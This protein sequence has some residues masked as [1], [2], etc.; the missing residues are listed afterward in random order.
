MDIAKAFEFFQ[1]YES[2]QKTEKEKLISEKIIKE[3]KERLKFL[4]DVGLD[5]LTLDRTAA[6]LSG[7]ES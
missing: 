3:I 6:T 5:Y 1:E 4:L 2:V 7:G